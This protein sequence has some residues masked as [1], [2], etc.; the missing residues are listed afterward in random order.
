MPPQHEP[1]DSRKA[2]ATPSWLHRY[3][4]LTAA[5]TLFLIVAGGLVTSTDS[6]LAVP[7]WPLSYG[8][9]FPPMVGGIF[10]EHGHRMIAGVVGILIFALAAWLWRSEK[11]S[12]VKWLGLSA[13]LAVIAQAV[14]GGLTVLFLLPS[15]I[16]IAHACLGQ[17]VFCLIVSL[18]VATGPSWA[19]SSPQIEDY[20]S[21]SLRVLSFGF[22]ASVV[23]QLIL[24]ALLRHTG[25]PV[26]V[27]VS[28]AL[29]V[30]ALG[31]WTAARILRT[32]PAVSSLRA[33]AIR[34]LALLG[35]QLVIGVFAWVFRSAV[36]VV[37][38]HVAVGA[39][40]LAQVWVLAW[41]VAR[42]TQGLRVFRRLALIGSRISV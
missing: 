10:Y 17:T 9:F 6:G 31:A 19:E 37:T 13:A 18:A 4:T 1:T 5:A 30:L 8:T 2:Q 32:R 7:D 40:L 42:S 35:I 15:Q 39:L 21:P 41:Q 16:S 33:H 28:G 29:A 3:A 23:A 12:W 27:H 11:R 25:M 38:A 24:G 22:L 36:P 26:A 14:L 34:S 20:R